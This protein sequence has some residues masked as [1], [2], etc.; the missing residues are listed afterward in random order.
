MDN[1]AISRRLNALQQIADR[2][3]PCKMTVTFADGSTTVTDPAG[4]W[5]V[6][7]DHMLV[8]DV[9]DVT[10]DRPEYSGLAGLVAILCHPVPNRRIEDF[11]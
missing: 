5:T 1:K 10:A 4:V 6:C 2:N 11:E 3:R 7:H 9:A 8:G